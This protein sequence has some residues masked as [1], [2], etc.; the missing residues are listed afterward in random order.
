VNKSSFTGILYKTVKEFL[1]IWCDD[2]NIILK[3]GIEHPKGMSVGPEGFI[4]GLKNIP[5][6]VGFV[7]ETKEI[8][9]DVWNLHRIRNYF[10]KFFNFYRSD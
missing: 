7:K 4:Q 3:Y 6:I 1:N 5:G 8:C 2:L 9:P 10:T